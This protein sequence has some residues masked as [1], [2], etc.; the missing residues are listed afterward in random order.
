MTE[1]SQI[2]LPSGT[3]YDLKDATA[4]QAVAGGVI[5]R[6]VTTTALT[7]GGSTNPITINSSS[8]TA[9]NGDLVLYGDQEFLYSTSD[10]KWHEFGNTTGLGS[11]AFKNSATGSFTPSG[12]VSKPNV[13]VSPTTATIKEFDGAGSVTAG[14]ANTPTAVTLPTLTMSVENEVLTM[15]WSAGSVT[16]GVACTP[17]AVTLPTSKETSVVTAV[18]AELASTPSFTGTAGTVTVT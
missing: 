10:N 3:T 18:S 16:A 8:Y 12:S 2:T 17:T 14:T 9:V 5:F 1:I 6:G 13:T 4:R 11:L 7:D 15:S